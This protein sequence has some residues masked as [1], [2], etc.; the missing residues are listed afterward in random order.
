MRVDLTKFNE[1]AGGDPVMG[2]EL[3]GDFVEACREQVAALKTAV[4]A[5]HAPKIKSVLH[6]LKGI[7]AQAGRSEAYDFLTTVETSYESSG[8]APLVEAFP[9]LD[10]LL[11]TAECD[12]VA[13]K[14]ALSSAS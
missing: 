2:A 4:A 13:L 14:A 12:A 11:S 10:E 6:A 8:V 3:A 1:W 7:I 5:D 9:V